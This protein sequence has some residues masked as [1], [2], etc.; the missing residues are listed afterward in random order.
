MDAIQNLLMGLAVALALQNLLLAFVGSVPGTE[1]GVLPGL[2]PSAG[3]AMRIPL[4]FQMGPTGAIIML[5]ALVS[6]T[7]YGRTIT[8]VLLNGPGEA[9]SATACLDGYAVAKQ[10]RAGVALSIAAIRPLSE[11]ASPPAPWCWR[12]DRSP[13]GRSSLGRRSSLP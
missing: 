2:G 4:T 9:A 6:G 8:S 10:G 3:A 5:T 1:I 11:A 13:G 12:R 7:Q